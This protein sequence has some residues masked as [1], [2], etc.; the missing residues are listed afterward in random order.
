MLDPRNELGRARDSYGGWGSKNY[1]AK[2]VK[3]AQNYES[4][5]SFD[6]GS[7][8]FRPG[9]MEEEES[10]VCSPPLWKTSPPRGPLPP[11]HPQRAYGHL[12][13][14]SKTQAIARGQWEL[15]EMVKSMPESSYE[16]SLKDLVEHTRVETQEECLVGEKNLKIFG[17]E[18]VDQRVKVMRQESKKNEKK[19]K[20]VRSGSIDNR[21]LFLKMVI[22]FYFGSKKKKKATNTCAK[23]SPKPEVSDRS[24]KGVDKDWWKKKVVGSG[25]SESGVTTSNSGSSGSSSSSSRSNSGRKMSAFIP[26]CWSFFCTKKSKTGK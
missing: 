7:V 4:Y 5:R 19:A 2:A 22:P 3:A 11:R 25:E 24:S 15:M 14:V 16:L 18:F 6:G 20:M 26:G 10:G 8:Q 9:N 12:S 21:G 1:G 17:S 13:P 23:V